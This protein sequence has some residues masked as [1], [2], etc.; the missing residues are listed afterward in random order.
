MNK[1]LGIFIALLI[2]AVA[3]T[4]FYFEKMWEPNHLL[5][6]WGAVSFTYLILTLCITPLVKI[7][8]KASL[9]IYRKIFGLLTFFCAL[10]HLFAYLYMAN[11]FD[12]LFDL[13]LYKNWDIIFW[14]IWFVILIILAITSNR[15]S[16]QKLGIFWKKLHSLIY[17]MFL[18]VLLHIAFASHFDIYYMVMIGVLVLLRSVAYL[19]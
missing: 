7:T 2:G 19:K 12:Q 11:K 8:K 10:G 5:R 14:I 16:M 4:F 18:I 3:Y 17:P 15:Y 13:N 1:F 6:V 9:I